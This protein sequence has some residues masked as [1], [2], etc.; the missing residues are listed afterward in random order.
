MN[1]DLNTEN[2]MDLP[3]GNFSVKET[4][5]V[6]MTN[7]R[8]E[9]S[10][11]LESGNLVSVLFEDKTQ[12]FSYTDDLYDI[13]DSSILE[14]HRSLSTVMGIPLTLSL[15]N[16]RSFSKNSIEKIIVYSRDNISVDHIFEYFDK[17]I[18]PE[19]QTGLF[20]VGKNFEK[21]RVTAPELKGKKILLFIHGTFS[22]FDKAFKDLKDTETWKHLT[23][24]YDKILAFNHKTISKSPLEN[25]AELLE[26]LPP[27]ID[28]D[29]VTHSRG[30][31]LADVLCRYDR[32]NSK[33]GFSEQELEL[34]ASSIPDEEN[35]SS[36]NNENRKDIVLKY[37]EG[38]QDKESRSR[39]I[40][41]NQVMKIAS[42][43]GGTSL[44]TKRLDHYLNFILNALIFSIG[45]GNPLISIIKEF[46]LEVLHCRMSVNSAPGLWAMSPDSEFQKIINNREIS[47]K[48]KI[49]CISGDGS[50]GGSLGNTLFVI[51]AHLFYLNDN[52]W[53]VDTKSMKKGVYNSEGGIYEYFLSGSDINHFLYFRHERI[54][55]QLA[56]FADENISKEEFRFITRENMDRGWVEQL[57][58]GSFETSLSTGK[59]PVFLIIPGIMGSTLRNKEKR[60]WANVPTF[61]KGDFVDKLSYSSSNKDVEAYG[62]I[63]TF[64]EK[65]ADKLSKFA[66][67]ELF[68]YDWREDIAVTSAKLNKRL[69]TL[70]SFNQ[71]TIL[72]HSMGGLLVR[73][74]MDGDTK[75]NWH[76]LMESSN[77]KTL[78]FGTPWRGSHL[79]LNIFAGEHSKVKLLSRIDPFH[80]KDEVI[81]TVSE[82]P[83]V[84][85]LLPF[86][87]DFT[88]NALWQSYESAKDGFVI[89]KNLE[90]YRIFR[91][92]ALGIKINDFKDRIFYIAGHDTSTLADI[93]VGKSNGMEKS[94]LV[95]TY[96]NAGDGSTVWAESIPKEDLYAKNIFY[97]G[98]KHENLLKEDEIFNLI[99]KIYHHEKIDSRYNSPRIKNEK[100]EFRSVTYV[101]HASTDEEIYNGL[102]YENSLDKDAPAQIRNTPLVVT[103][104]NADLKF[105]HHP[106]MLGHFKNDGIYS[107]EKRLDGLLKNK[108]SERHS[109]GL[110]PSSIGDCEIILQ[111]SEQTKGGIIVGLGKQDELSG[112]NLT[113]AIESAVLKY[114][115]QYRDSEQAKDHDMYS[116]LSISTVLIGSNYAGLSINESI[117]SMIA[118]IKK[119]NDKVI[120]LDNGLKTIGRLE[121]VEYYEDIAQQSFKELYNE[122]FEDESIEIES[123]F[124]TGLGNKK[125]ILRSDRSSWWQ[126][127]TTAAI[128]S[129]NS[130]IYN[131][132]VVGLTHT[133]NSGR[134]R[135][136]QKTVDGNMKLAEFYVKEFS[137]ERTY[138]QNFSKTL[139]ELLVPNDFKSILKQQKNISWKMD[140]YAAQFPWEMLHDYTTSAEPA[141]IK[142]G[143]IRQLYTDDY[144]V[145][146]NIIENKKAIVI[147]PDY[148]DSMKF[149]DLPAAKAEAESVRNILKNNQFETTDLIDAKTGKII[150]DL[151]SNEYKII[152][153]S[154]HGVFEEDKE[155][156]TIQSGIVLGDEI[157]LDPDTIKQLSAIPEFMFINCCYSGKINTQMMDERN[158]NRVSLAASI[159][160][161]LI[162]MGVK[163]VVISGWA[164]EDSAAKTFSE[165]LYKQLFKGK[166]FGEAVKIAR[167]ECY[168][169]HRKTNTWAAYQCYGEYYY[170]L[171]S[172]NTVEDAADFFMT[173][174]I[175]KIELE[176][177]LSD[178][179]AGNPVQEY[180]EKFKTRIFDTS[181]DTP[182]VLEILAIIYYESELFDESLKIINQLTKQSNI[183]YNINIIELYFRIQT[184]K[185]FIF[186]EKDKISFTEFLNSIQKQRYIN[187]EN[188]KSI[189][190]NYHKKEL[191][192]CVSDSQDD[193]S[194]LL[195]NKLN[196]VLKNY[197]LPSDHS[198]LQGYINEAVFFVLHN[199]SADQAGIIEKLQFY[200]N[201][202]RQKDIKDKKS[203][204]NA[205]AILLLNN[206]SG[207]E[208]APEVNKYLPYINRDN[209]TISELYDILLNLEFLYRITEKLD[210][211]EKS[212][213]INLQS[214]YLNIK[215]SLG[216]LSYMETEIRIPIT[217]E[218]P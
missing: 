49:Y 132:Q 7:T 93:E 140:D 151:F 57:T 218:T 87:K 48:P 55:N 147:N 25:I 95:Y 62:A 14:K 192:H 94:K 67:V 126:T 142:T 12:W 101:D 172:Q 16:N 168:T 74:L 182:E 11:K 180:L 145:N 75:S 58:Y 61:F 119:A 83:G 178:I 81:K 18:M 43:S 51:M 190:F 47:V 210:I 9:S 135:I 106:V 103:V 143:M 134:A 77:N 32:R 50:L 111:P 53:V 85:Q 122:F 173:E 187:F 109:Y 154:G 38:L 191:L 118:G 42:P 15:K 158:I 17:K 169:K 162:K 186:Q 170:K 194:L 176:N 13:Y 34:L 44:M 164:V 65:M 125:R 217:T 183:S 215:K 155:K 214:L 63:A 82:F 102:L 20:E 136:D 156:H 27:E 46:L 41:V 39:S 165:V 127:F 121:I 64:Y 144:Q 185:S 70:A 193:I 3:I 56:L 167:K 149:P 86:N 60:L 73:H 45:S 130:N 110:Y 115:I 175:A 31:L 153:I 19:E 207:F 131:R 195:K 163:A 123:S 157:L 141:F 54:R 21:E 66:D 200:Y 71:V 161:Q 76:R 160:T 139:F 22:S 137:S 24:K 100:T 204:L 212:T 148:T 205:F 166:E 211:P 213:S 99:L 4:I 91:D 189:I 52:D 59:R 10:Q 116:E 26:L 152:H 209:F 28:L 113:K 198:N 184:Q 97:T 84:L 201:D 124:Q 188:I 174:S 114:S 146:P 150:N 37:F 89:P 208:S 2:P 177:I 104:F 216:L 35:T 159:G 133:A 202:C 29:L 92:R 138:D 171:V 112:F 107:A 36:E 199:D 69:E 68:P 105:A 8:G 1:T 33:I 40:T 96:T 78:F 120:L 197:P 88:D 129:K 30:G 79:I 196:E 72:A 181:C 23:S 128:Y 108:L 179:R 203:F 5:S 117:N 90:Y 6:Q 80:G 98:A 206:Y